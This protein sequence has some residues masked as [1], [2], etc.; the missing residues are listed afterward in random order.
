MLSAGRTHLLFL[1]SHGATSQ[2]TSDGDANHSTTSK[3]TTVLSI[4]PTYSSIELL[5]LLASQCKP[6]IPYTSDLGTVETA[7][8]RTE[9]S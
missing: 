8:E 2:P 9:R 3:S 6:A 7:V 4:R 1:D 5:E